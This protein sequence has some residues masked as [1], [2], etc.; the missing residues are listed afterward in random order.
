MD[1]LMGEQASH[2]RQ[3]ASFRLRTYQ[4]IMRGINKVRGLSPFVRLGRSDVVQVAFP[5]KCKGS[6]EDSIPAASSFWFERMFM[7]F[8]T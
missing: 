4:K 2:E 1:D 8:R 3:I 7:G 5:P 6:A